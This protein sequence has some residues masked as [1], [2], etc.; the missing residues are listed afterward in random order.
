MEEES[1]GN[2]LA[3]EA[4]YLKSDEN[5][6]FNSPPP[7]KR[8]SK[9]LVY[10]LLAVVLQSIAFLIF[11]LVVLRIRPPSLQ[12]STAAVT[13]LRYDSASLNMTVVAG[14]R[15]HNTNFG[16]FEF[17]GGSAALLYENATIG[18]ANLDAGRIGGR[19]KREMNVRVMVTGG[20]GHQSSN[21]S[22]DIGFGWVKLRSFAELRGE[23]RVVKMMN[24]RRTA[25]MNCTM[26]LNVTS[27]EIQDLSCQ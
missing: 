3:P 15:L 7:I 16:R 9:C 18:A 2:P 4:K 8:S 5:K 13:D 17:Q 11:G 27:Q 21:L 26:N 20:P 14:I 25:F 22:R 1:Y 6:P 19:E 24:R 23:V 12:L 10:I